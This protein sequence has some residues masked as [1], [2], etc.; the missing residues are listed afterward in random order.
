VW[1]ANSSIEYE[2]ESNHFLEM[3]DV[4]TMENRLKDEKGAERAFQEMEKAAAAV[5]SSPYD[6]VEKARQLFGYLEGMSLAYPQY[7][8]RAR[9][10]REN[11]SK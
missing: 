6:G 7:A 11:L 4:F 1:N 2:D 10:D 8:R 5:A 9:A 3:S